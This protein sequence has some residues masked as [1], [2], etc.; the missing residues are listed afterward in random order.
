ML[1]KE[2]GLLFFKITRFYQLI[3]FIRRNADNFDPS[4]WKDPQRARRLLEQGMRMIN[5]S[6]NES[7]LA[8][9]VLELISICN[10]EENEI[11]KI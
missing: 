1:R 8:P 9:I 3:N 4:D 5:D 11:I 7:E 10:L 6:T 2:L